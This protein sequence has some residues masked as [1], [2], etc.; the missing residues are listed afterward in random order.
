M[1]DRRIE[2]IVLRMLQLTA[3]LDQPS[4]RAVKPLRDVRDE[5]YDYIEYS[6]QSLPRAEVN[7]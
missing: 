6:R 1:E 5:L 4:C 3:I 2:V 7:A